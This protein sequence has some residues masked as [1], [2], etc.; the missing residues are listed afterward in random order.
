M[1]ITQSGKTAHDT[2]CN[3]AELTR[4][5]AV[6]A[7]GNNQASVTAAEIIYFKAVAK[8]CRDNNGGS[9]IEVAMTALKSLGVSGA[10]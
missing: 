6:A 10:F 1:S 8:S 5:N 7:A 4:Q 3:S 2:A 9:G